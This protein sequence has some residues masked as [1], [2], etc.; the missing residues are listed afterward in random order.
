[1]KLSR[2]T[3]LALLLLLLLAGL[4]TAAAWKQNAAQL[5]ALS[6]TSPAP[7]GALALRLWAREL[8]Y[9]VSDGV[10]IAYTP[11]KEAALALVLQPDEFTSSELYMLDRWVKAGGTLIAAGDSPG[12]LTLAKH[13]EMPMTLLGALLD[14]ARPQAPVLASPPLEDPVT[15]L[16]MWAFEPERDDYA[17]LFAGRGYPLMV[18]FELEQGHVILSTASYPFTNIGLKQAGNPELLLNLLSTG[19]AGSL[20]WFD[21]WHHG[22]RTGRQVIGP[23]NWLRYTAA[24]RSLLFVA[25]VIFLALLLG[26]RNFGRPAP[27]PHQ[28][29]R[30]GPLDHLNAIANLNRRAGHRAATLRHYRQQVKRYWGRRY[31]LDPGLPDD[32]FVASLAA[33]NPGLDAPALLALLRDL[34]TPNPSE[35]DMVRLA[36]GASKWL[37]E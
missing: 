13:Y 10:D 28:V 32:R 30:R 35:A 15:L 11:P 23:Q 29:R 21:E 16:T 34:S 1:M 22:F 19:P 27:L 5:P 6:S 17:A 31:R 12:M 18:S 20:L 3:L 26:G 4:M 14:E 7:N 2:D 37:E 24:G 8:G 36:A 33:C 9:Q 25:G